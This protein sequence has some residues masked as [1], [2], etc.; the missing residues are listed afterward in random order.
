M[1]YAEK[2]QDRAE[3]LGWVKDYEEIIEISPQYKVTWS[4]AVRFAEIKS[5]EHMAIARI[6]Q[7]KS[8]LAKALLH[9]AKHRAQWAKEKEESKSEIPE[10]VREWDF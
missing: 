9:K 3:K 8:Y 2:S 7:D 6:V 10:W 4:S 1:E 5:E